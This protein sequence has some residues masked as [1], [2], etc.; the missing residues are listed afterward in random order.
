MQLWD[1][2]FK[3]EGFLGEIFIKRDILQLGEKE[4]LKQP[5]V[6]KLCNDYT[7]SKWP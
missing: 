5:L 7:V 3:N 6:D 1:H 4:I 2:V